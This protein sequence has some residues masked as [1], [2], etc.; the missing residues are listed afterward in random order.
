MILADIVKDY[1]LTVMR[2][3]AEIEAGTLSR[4]F[5]PLYERARADL[6]AEGLANTGDERLSLLPALDMRYVGQSYE[7]TVELQ[8]RELAPA[9]PG[10]GSDPAPTSYL[11]RF[12]ATHR[13]RFSYASEQEP[14]EI[15]NLRLKAVGHTAKPHFSS[16]PARGLDPKAAQVGYK[17]VYFALGDSSQVARPIP[18]ALYERPRLQSGNIVVGPAIVFQLDTTTVIP[19]G[20]AAT[21]DGWGNMVMEQRGS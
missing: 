21:V 13:R 8:E 9:A 14:V 18:T 11:D 6:Q 7:L 2:P 10:G 20:W 4:L 17:P 16:Q 19:P 5:A 3:A 12:H 15:V 1:S